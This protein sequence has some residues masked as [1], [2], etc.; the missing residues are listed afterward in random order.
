MGLTTQGL[1][2]WLGFFQAAKFKAAKLIGCLPNL[3]I[4]GLIGMD[5]LLLTQS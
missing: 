5:Q 2:I 3:E 4:E 1:S